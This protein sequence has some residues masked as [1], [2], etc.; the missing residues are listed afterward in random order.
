M[1]R[2]HKENPILFAVLWIII[3]VVGLSLADNASASLGIEKAVTL[4]LALVLSLVLYSWISR[5]NL[6]EYCGLCPSAVPESRLLWYFPLGALASVNLWFGVNMNLSVPETVLYV[7]SMFC[8]GFLEEV[9]FRGLLFKAMVP[10]GLKT[11]VAVSSL[12][13]GMGHLV[14]LI[15]GSGADLFASLLQ[16]VY[17]FAAGFLF[18]ILFLR[19]GS[20]RA[21]ILTHGVLNAL[22]AF[23]NE[24]VRTTGRDIFSAAALTLIALGY[25]AYILK[26]TESRT[27]KTAENR[28]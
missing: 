21:C 3:Y 7:A 25:A 27:C 20:I 28:P 18:T 4:P 23:A 6:K 13:F 1:N 10:L 8:V 5:Q 9:I 15:N 22:S 26:V 12:T 11:A 24:A 16:V 14:N 2:L 19:T 17:A